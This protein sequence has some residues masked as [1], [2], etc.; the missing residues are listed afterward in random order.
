MPVVIAPGVV[1]LGESVEPKSLDQPG[2]HNE[3][4]FQKNRKKFKLRKF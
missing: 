2:Q 3:I 1:G 4:S